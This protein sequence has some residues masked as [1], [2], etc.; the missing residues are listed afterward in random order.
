QATLIT[1]IVS[2]DP[3]YCYMDADERSI[4]KYQQ[5]TRE[6]RQENMRAGQVA[7]EL[8][9]ANETNF[10]HKG[11]LDFMDNRLDATMGTL[12]VRGVFPNPAPD[13]VLQPGF[14]ARVRVPGPAKYPAL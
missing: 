9:L 12:R 6:G 11:V 8:E 1:T 3:I 7:C 4:L 14:F 13:R 2:V 10:P 5:L